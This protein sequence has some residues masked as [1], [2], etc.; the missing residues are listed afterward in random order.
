MPEA[1]VVPVRTA[2]ERF[3]KDAFGSAETDADGDFIVRQAGT[4][5]WVRVQPLD[6]EHTAVVLFSPAAV[7]VRVDGELTSCLATEGLDLDL[8]H[9]ELHDR[10][11]PMVVVSHTLLGEYLSREELTTAI[12]EVS[13]AARRHGP[14]ISER[15][16]GAV[17]GASARGATPG[18]RDLEELLGA[19]TGSQPQP[20]SG[21][22]LAA[23]LWLVALIGGVAGGIFAQRVTSSWWLAA[24]VLFMTLFVVGRALPDI[25]T[26]PDKLRRAAYFG[27]VP[28]LSTAVLALIYW[29]SGWWWLAVVLGLVLGVLGSATLGALFFA[30]IAQEE[31][32]QDKQG[33]R[34]S[35]LAGGP[36]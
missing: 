9:F 13:S 18:R 30:D 7:G 31:L 4:V 23:V 16:G 2:V 19:L 35:Y 10:Q 24:F 25:L 36:P 26:E 8:A 22:R 14:R 34:R 33:E 15:F 1:G 17:A 32:E 27:S 28:V 12:D 29:A 20:R 3:L 6:D 11:T 5:T 21:E